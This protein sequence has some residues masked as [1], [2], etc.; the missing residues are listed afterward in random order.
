M[1]S[2]PLLTIAIPTYNRLDSLRIQLNRVAEV[3]SSEVEIIISDNGSTDGTSSFLRKASATF[4]NMSF[5]FNVSNEGFDKNISTLHRAATGN[6]VWFLSDDDIINPEYIWQILCVLKS[7]ID[8]G[9]IALNLDIGARDS[10]R[11]RMVS[12]A[13]FGKRFNLPINTELPI[14][15]SK[16]LQTLV[17]TLVSQISTCII[18]RIDNTQ[19][20][21]D[22]GGLA[23]VN[24][25]HQALAVHPRFY[26]AS[27]KV[28]RLG[29]KNRISNWFLDSCLNGVE[30]AYSN[31]T[32]SLGVE[33]CA[34]VI[35]STKIL[36][37]KIAFSALGSSRVDFELEL[38]RHF[39]PPAQARLKVVYA[40]WF[41][42]VQLGLRLTIIPRIFFTIFRGYG[43][44]KQK[45]MITLK[46]H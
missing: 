18:R 2:H 24:L 13:N 8:V 46:N 43:V 42:L 34:R 4:E 21:F 20:E 40:L 41:I 19:Y 35:G 33:N 29:Q 17:G 38:L 25:V 26:I 6:Y 22:G 9:A 16:E 37:L 15:G 28:I 7:N 44:F 23:H 3:R 39:R 32:H 31:L 30:I 12:Y 27:T 5:I 11:T 14:S 1:I 45:F 36:G 10:L